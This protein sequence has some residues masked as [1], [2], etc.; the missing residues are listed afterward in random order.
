MIKNSTTG[1]GSRNWAH[2]DSTR[3]YANVGNHTL[4][5]NLNEGEGFFGTGVNVFGTSNKI[6]ILSN[7][8]KIRENNVFS[9]T[10][11]DVYI[12]VA[13]AEN[14]FGGS[15]VNPATAR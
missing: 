10:S 4:A 6:D 3:S 5:A 12:F 14:P 2:I 11:S 9:N 15:G 1:G 8:F 13:F 7:G